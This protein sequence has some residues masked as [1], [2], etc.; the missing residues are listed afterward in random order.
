MLVSGNLK[1]EYPED[2]EEVLL[3]RGLM[4]VNIPKFLAHDLPL[5]AGIISD[6]FPGVQKPE[7][8]YDDLRRGCGVHCNKVGIQL[9]EV[10]RRR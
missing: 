8:Q 6:L 7:V 3:L 4:D 2:D 5:Y 9:V 10:R 1:R